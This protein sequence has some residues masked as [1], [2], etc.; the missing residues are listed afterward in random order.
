MPPPGI[1]LQ[2]SAEEQQ[3]TTSSASHLNP[4]PPTPTPTTN[5]QPRYTTVGQSLALASLVFIVRTAVGGW[6]MGGSGGGHLCTPCIAEP[7]IK[8][9]RKTNTN[10][11]LV[12][13]KGG[14]GVHSSTRQMASPPASPH[15]NQT[16]VLGRRG[17]LCVRTTMEAFL[18]VKRAVTSIIEAGLSLQTVNNSA[19]WWP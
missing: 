16:G 9:Q 12:G 3:R 2:I 4:P 14:G 6:E 1:S 11:P 17:N 8:K 5:R 19:N 10:L 18:S 13:M 7:G 15:G